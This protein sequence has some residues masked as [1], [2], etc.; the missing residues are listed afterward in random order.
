[1]N[2]F[3][4]GY[5][6][7]GKTSAGRSLSDILGWP[8]I[9]ADFQLVKELGM[10]ISEIVLKNDW[11]FFREKEEAVLKKICSLDNHIIATGGGVVLNKENTANMKKCGVI[12]WLKVTPETVKK[13]ILIDNK[14]KD[15]RPSLT[16]KEIDEEIEETILKRRPLYENAMDFFIDTDNLD[17]NGVCKAI[18]ANLA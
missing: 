6:G 5:R 14:T 12:V 2:I 18:M 10:T 13:R 15:F 7:S 11:K 17:I 8:F 9:D 3:L 1:M 4:I 16:S